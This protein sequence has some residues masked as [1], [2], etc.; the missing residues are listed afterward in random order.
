M[1]Q[2]TDI[3]LDQSIAENA[4]GDITAD[5]DIAVDNLAH[6]AYQTYVLMLCVNW[7]V[8]LHQDVE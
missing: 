1:Y 5:V 8:G 2:A 6:Q 7:P 4:I 3:Q